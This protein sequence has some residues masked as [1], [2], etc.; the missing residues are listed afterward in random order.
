MTYDS[1][2]THEWQR[3]VAG[4][5][6]FPDKV[7]RGP[8]LRAYDA[9]DRLLLERVI[10]APEFPSEGYKGPNPAWY[11]LAANLRFCKNAPI[12]QVDFVIGG[13]NGKFSLVAPGGAATV[14]AREACT[15]Y[16]GIRPEPQTADLHRQL[17]VVDGTVQLSYY[18]LR[19]PNQ[20]DVDA[21]RALVPRDEL[22]RMNAE[23]RA[24][25]TPIC[26]TNS[27]ASW[28]IPACQVGG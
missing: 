26:K 18:R 6:V 28:K 9:D 17:N 16:L 3:P 12:D 13:H 15:E 5:V 21:N 11:D 10:E 25:V 1:D 7:D 19:D 20:P 8:T 23:R 2:V 14:E 27:K 24:A 22:L 4:I